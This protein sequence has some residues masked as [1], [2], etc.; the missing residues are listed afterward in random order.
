[1]PSILEN[2]NLPAAYINRWYAKLMKGDLDAAIA[3]CDQ[4]IKLNPKTL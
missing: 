3:D 4:A 2:A 1:V